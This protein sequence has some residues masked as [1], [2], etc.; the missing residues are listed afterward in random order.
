[1]KILDGFCY[2]N[3]LSLNYF[4]EDVEWILL[5]P[6]M[7]YVFCIFVQ[8]ILGFVFCTLRMNLIF[9]K[10]SYRAILNLNLRKW[11]G[12]FGSG[13]G[14]PWPKR[15]GFGAEI[16]NPLGHGSGLGQPLKTGFRVWGGLDPPQPA[17]LPSLLTTHLL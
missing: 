2:W 12:S 14:H 10:L 13:L 9:I 1:M 4:G 17:P 8:V 16:E 6:K 11:I 15:I 3:F 7:L 5:I